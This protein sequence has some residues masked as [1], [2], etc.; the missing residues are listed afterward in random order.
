MRQLFISHA[1]ENKPDVEALI[2]DLDA[3]GYQTW[4]DS[5]LR[6]GQTW[7]EEI[8]RR[9]AESDVFVAIVSAHTLNSVAC[10]LELEW[11]LALNK[12]VLPVGVERLPQALPLTLSTRQIVDY[13]KPGKEAAFALAGALG[14]LPAAPPAR[15]QLAEPPPAP[16]SYLSDLMEQV[17]QPEPLTHAQ[18]HQILIQLQPALRSAD[19]EERE[20]GRY[21]LKMFSRRDD[22]YADVDRTLAQLE[23]A[24]HLDVAA[25]LEQAARTA[26]RR[27]ALVDEMTS[28]HQAG[29]WDAVVA[30]AQELAGLDP[31]HPD[32]G[33]IV[34]DAKAKIRH[35]DLSERSGQAWA[36]A[37]DLLSAI[38]QQQPGDRDAARPARVVRDRG[39]RAGAEEFR[40]AGD[41]QT[42]DANDPFALVRDSADVV[43]EV[44]DEGR[45]A[46]DPWA[47]LK[48]LGTDR[49]ARGGDV[50]V[51]AV[52]RIRE[53]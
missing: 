52:A 1:R 53:V 35:A 38:E 21:V 24:N 17:G 10:K 48:E 31:E 3:L 34:S 4:V 33:G 45:G 39:A 15:E 14:T 41:L 16:L 25:R 27:K 11:A 47:A 8:L 23:L 30:A 42:E 37:A 6:G 7:W 26:Q 32:P 13:S 49:R 46:R 28:L 40:V 51:K 20:G 18:Q 9:I 36:Q 19:P 2:R 5:S 43:G 22:L 12:P 50:A 44:L 29:Q